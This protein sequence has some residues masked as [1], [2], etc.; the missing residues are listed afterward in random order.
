MN[1]NH[2]PP[3]TRTYRS[4]IDAWLLTV[5][6][7][8]I[9]LS[10]V[11][12]LYAGSWLVGTVVGLLL[13]APTVSLFRIRYVVCG[14]RL[15]VYDGLLFSQTYDIGQ[16]RAIRATRT[17]LSAPAASIDRLEICFHYDSVVVSPA[18]KQAFVDHLRRLA[19]GNIKVEL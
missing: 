5:L 9:G 17:L 10:V 11:P 4:K 16:I 19:A 18:D 7:A 1:R 8:T 2:L 14:T 12:L 6:I 3:D 15:T 13:L